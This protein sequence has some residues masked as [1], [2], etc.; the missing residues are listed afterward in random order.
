MFPLILISS[1]VSCRRSNRRWVY[2]FLVA[3][4]YESV[5]NLVLNGCV[6][7]AK[8]VTEELSLVFFIRTM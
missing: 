7:Y 6:C 1:G 2:G 4:R 5:I 8:C 3:S